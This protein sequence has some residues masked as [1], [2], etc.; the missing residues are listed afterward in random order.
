MDGGVVA[1]SPP[2]LHL[3][4][5]GVEDV[6]SPAPGDLAAPAEHVVLPPMER[7]APSNR[8]PASVSRQQQRL[9]QTLEDLELLHSLPRL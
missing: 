7:Q 3:D 9:L 8:R 1:D 2:P 6:P 5:D 4:I